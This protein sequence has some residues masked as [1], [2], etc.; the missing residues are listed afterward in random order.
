MKYS[1]NGHKPA[2]PSYTVEFF[3]LSHEKGLRSDEYYRAI[4]EWIKTGSRSEGLAE[5]RRIAGEYLRALDQ[6]LEYLEKQNG[7]LSAGE[8]TKTA[9]QLR[10]LLQSDIDQ[11]HLA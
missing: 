10:S 7:S 1:E 8:L 6:Y 9:S 11:F 3:Q 4:C 5:R 2:P